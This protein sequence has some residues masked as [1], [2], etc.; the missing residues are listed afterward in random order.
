[1]LHITYPLQMRC[2]SQLQ[3][4]DCFLLVPL[5]DVWHL[6]TDVALWDVIKAVHKGVY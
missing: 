3:I 1:M 6:E 2:C 5:L 4:L